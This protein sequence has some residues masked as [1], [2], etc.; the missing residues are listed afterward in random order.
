MKR[1]LHWLLLDLLALPGALARLLCAAVGDPRL[2]LELNARWH[3]ATTCPRCPAARRALR[4]AR[5]G[6]CCAWLW[7]WTRGNYRI[8]PHFGWR[9]LLTQY[10][11][12]ADLSAYTALL[13][14]HDSPEKP[15]LDEAPIS[16]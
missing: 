8:P 6:S 10:A 7:H 5:G 3:L 13:P 2:G 4:D 15:P 9:N 1:T 12:R 16:S 14:P 11:G